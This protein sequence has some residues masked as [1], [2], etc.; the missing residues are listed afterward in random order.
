MCSQNGDFFFN[1]RCLISEALCSPVRRNVNILT[2]GLHASS[3]SSGE[4]LG[5]LLDW[6]HAKA[7]SEPLKLTWFKTSPGL[8][9]LY[10]GKHQNLYTKKQKMSY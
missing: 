3:H 1:V 7:I 4:I 8:V 10:L 2:A 6:P 9:D 5:V